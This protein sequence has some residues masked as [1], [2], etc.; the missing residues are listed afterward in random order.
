MNVFGDP[1]HGGF[2]YPLVD[3]SFDLRATLSEDTIPSP[4]GLLAERDA[5][6]E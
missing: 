6:Q 1:D 3:F 2:E 4:V 5:L